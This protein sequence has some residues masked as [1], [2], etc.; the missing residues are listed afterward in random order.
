[1]F[2]WLLDAVYAIENGSK[3]KIIIIMCFIMAQQFD[4]PFDISLVRLCLRIIII[5]VLPAALTFNLSLIN[6]PPARIIV[7]NLL[8]I[9]R[10]PL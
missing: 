6:N 5:G 3:S 4:A 1:M 9:F 7:I 2:N 10:Q 8:F